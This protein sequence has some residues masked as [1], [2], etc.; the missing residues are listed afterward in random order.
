MEEAFLNGKAFFVFISNRN[1]DSYRGK[2]S[3]DLECI[4]CCISNIA[5][6]FNLGKSGKTNLYD[7]LGNGL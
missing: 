6:G 1:D 3:E 2:G 5:Q 4:V 7:T